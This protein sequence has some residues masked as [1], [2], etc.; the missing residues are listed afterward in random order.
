MSA[1]WDQMLANLMQ[2]VSESLGLKS[3]ATC[4]LYKVL[5]YETGGFFKLHR[6]TE[7][8]ERMFGTLIV[9]LPSLYTGG[10]LIVQ[11]KGKKQVYDMAKENEFEFQYI[12]FFADC[13]HELKR[14]TSGY[15]LCLVYNM[16]HP[17]TGALP[18]PLNV[19]DMVTKVVALIKEWEQNPDGPSKV[20]ILLEHKYTQAGLSFKALKNADLAKVELL[21]KAREQVEFDVHLALITYHQ[22]GYCSSDDDENSNPQMEVRHTSIE[23]NNWIRTTDDKVTSYDRVIIEEDEVFPADDISEHDL[24]H[25]EIEPTGNAGTSMERWYEIAALIIW[26]RG[27]EVDILVN[28]G[29]VVEHLKQMVDKYIAKEEPAN[30]CVWKNCIRIAEIIVDKH[31]SNWSP[32]MTSVVIAINDLDLCR[33][34]INKCIPTNLNAVV[35]HQVISLCDA[36]GWDK[37]DLAPQ[38]KKMAVDFLLGLVGV[39]ISTPLLPSPRKTACQRY[40]RILL[41]LLP[42]FSTTE[43]AATIVTWFKV[44]YLLDLHSE[45]DQV[46]QVF[47]SNTNYHTF[48][49]EA[50]QVTLLWLGP[51]AKLSPE[52]ITFVGGAYNKYSTKR[53]P[54]RLWDRSI[55]TI[56]CNCEDCVQL[57]QFLLSDSLQR[58][59]FAAV[60][61]RRK[62]VEGSGRGVDDVEFSTDTNGIPHKLIATKTQR[63]Y[64]M[65]CNEYKYFVDGAKQL[66]QVLAELTEEEQPTD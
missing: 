19:T 30:S 22:T 14:V 43:S 1:R 56:M 28:S 20:A 54:R 33:N 62:H 63:K 17:G 29:N 24:I 18:M 5:L 40:A 52:F 13:E 34:Y 32:E 55:H 12:A 53:A 9:Q 50:T 25:Q 60:K 61:K 36:F 64:E 11:H 38:F 44:Y 41:Q 46:M 23:A 21:R 37:V 66:D 3:V 51:K 4:N 15:R 39:K 27:H 2:N 16:I 7:K 26:P 59:V 49:L 48:L 58:W 57:K 10:E 45:L 8:E 42:S 35:A 6:D 47:L 65:K 31:N